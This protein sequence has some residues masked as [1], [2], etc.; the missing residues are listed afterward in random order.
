MGHRFLLIFLLIFLLTGLLPT[1]AMSA[2]ID[3]TEGDK[4]SADSQLFW[5][6]TTPETVLADVLAGACHL[7][8]ARAGDLSRGLD[9]RAFW[10]R[11]TLKNTR[12][13]AVERWIWVGHPRL[14]EVSLFAPKRVAQPGQT[15]SEN[16]IHNWSRLDSGIGTPFARRDPVSRAYGPLPVVVGPGSEQT[17]WLRVASRTAID[18]S[19][20]IWK[21]AALQ[22]HLG[23]TQFSLTLAIGALFIVMMFSGLIFVI[24]REWVYLFF[25]LSMFGEIV[26]ESF[27]SALLQRYLLPPEMAMPVELA[28]LGSCLAVLG[29]TLFFH[30]F[31]PTLSN[32]SVLS[33][34]FIVLIGV[35]L[36]AQSWSIFIDYR[37]GAMVWSVSV[38]IAI[39]V[40]ISLAMQAWRK[41]I[42][43]AR[44]L[45]FNFA[46]LAALELLRLGA[47]LGGLP[48]FWVETMAGPWAL[49]MTTP[50]I[51]MGV[52]QRSRELH[53][54]L[55]RA[56]LENTARIEFLA[57]MSHELRSP[58]DTILGNAQLLALP[59]GKH[60]AP[61]G[62][63][64]IQQSGKHLLSMLD[65]ILD[66]ARG[67]AG[68][69]K[70]DPAPVDLQ[71]FLTRFARNATQL[72]RQNNNRFSLLQDGDP[73]TNVLL[74]DGRLQQVL[75]NLLSNAVRHTRNGSISLEC[76]AIKTEAGQVRL[77]FQVSD[78]SDGILEEDLGRIFLP[79]ERGKNALSKK[80]KGAGMGLAI[81]SQLI[82]AMGGKLSVESKIGQGARFSFSMLCALSDPAPEILSI[83]AFS[84]YEGR[85][86]CILVID[87]EVNT[88]EVLGS[89]LAVHG[90]I[91]RKAKNGLEALEDIRLFGSVDLVL[92]EQ[93]M[94]ESDG[95]AVL[96]G[97]Y[98][99][100][101]DVPVVLMSAGPPTRPAGF[102]S[103]VNF[104]AFLLK[105]L[106][107]PTLLH[108]LGNLLRLNWRHVEQVDRVD[109]TEMKN[110]EF[111]DE[112]TLQHLR[113][114]IDCGAI[115]EMMD[116]ATALKASQPRYSLFA[117]RVYIA[118]YGI[119]LPALHDLGKTSD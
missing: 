95:W 115:T 19:T 13:V 94:E 2:A 65:E 26:I 91:V 37:T 89:L 87:D 34:I 31:V 12:S 97:S 61:D 119:D 7:Q 43:S 113:D 35:T 81:S 23:R 20:T 50:L 57:Q 90:F 63:T 58:L 60:L 25:A 28:A 69:L 80:R 14:E 73:V 110:V 11:I 45:V 74:D 106:D 99:L 98:R 47:V 52:F 16:S 70:I 86:R 5:C 33:R 109:E 51:L 103:E 118:A 6:A 3:V 21:P 48:F 1:T 30:A 67:I 22:E 66:H 93:F 102:T 8:L 85:R 27:R 104:S 4:V 59:S 75:D 15:L 9:A 62:L 64:I 56:E 17:I 78:S 36:A 107:H 114:L 32:K 88:L 46:F 39:L 92:V 41:G 105:P 55:I 84:E 100:L 10:M 96:Q 76:H 53:D 44:T 42:R 24:S 108:T 18:I 68:K 82:T 116:W 101:P 117:D 71:V 77:D 111:P 79:F 83:S 38:N 72:A 54:K 49:V 29:F 40:G 112:A